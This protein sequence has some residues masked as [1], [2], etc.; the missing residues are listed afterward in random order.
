MWI[1]HVVCVMRGPSA[2]V[3]EAL[4]ALMTPVL[5]PVLAAAAQ[6]AKRSSSSFGV[7]GELARAI[8]KGSAPAAATAIAAAAACA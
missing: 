4:L 8:A 6:G 5:V 2:P 7:R 1:A 3:L